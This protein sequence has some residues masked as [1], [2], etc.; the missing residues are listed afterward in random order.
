VPSADFTVTSKSASNAAGDTTWFTF[1]GDP[2]NLSFYSGEPGHEYRF[3]DR[4]RA[5]G[6]PQLQFST[7]RASGNA[8]DTLQVLMST[9][10][11]AVY[12]S[13]NIYQATW[14]DIT[15]RAV[16]A[17]T[18]VKPSG[19]VDLSDFVKDTLPVYLAYRYV[20]TTHAGAQTTWTVS[21]I[22][23]TNV[24]SDSSNVFSVGTVADG[25]WQVVNMQSKA[26]KWAVSATQ[27]QAKGLA[28]ANSAVAETWVISRP[29]MLKRAIPDIGVSLKNITNN[30]LLTYPYIYKTAGTYTATFVGVNTTVYDSK[31]SVKDVKVQVN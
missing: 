26:V 4:T 19:I 20:G 17:T 9:D 25:V 2:Y 8:G 1:T 21:A 7:V 30:S 29:L 22:A 15:S 14:T 11:K 13:T 6:T 5:D 10:F 18:S 3:R 28:A 23:V 24:A 31:S 12:D 27:L 16:L